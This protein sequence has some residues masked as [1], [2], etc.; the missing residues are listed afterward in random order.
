MQWGPLSYGDVSVIWNM[1]CMQKKLSKDKYAAPTETLIQKKT[2]NAK[3]VNKEDVIHV[4]FTS[5]R[6]LFSTSGS[7]RL[8]CPINNNFLSF[9]NSFWFLTTYNRV[10]TDKNFWIFLTLKALVRTAADHRFFT[11]SLWQANKST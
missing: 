4:T 3:L 6:I 10:I 9:S 1:M 2:R 7:V 11:F 8:N 5:D